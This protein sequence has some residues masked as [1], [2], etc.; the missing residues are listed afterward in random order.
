MTTCSTDPEDAAQALR[1]DMGAK[2]YLVT[3][4]DTY[5]EDAKIVGEEHVNERIVRLKQWRGLEASEL[6]TITK[7]ICQV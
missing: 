5:T 1:S 7:R 6:A 2:V 3:V 4:G